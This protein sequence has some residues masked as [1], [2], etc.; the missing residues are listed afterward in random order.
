MWGTSSFICLNQ[1]LRIDLAIKNIGKET[2]MYKEIT[3]PYG[4]STLNVRLPGRNVVAVL[5][6]KHVPGLKDERAAIFKAL[7]QPVDSPPLK[8]CLKPTDKVVIIVTDNTRA[9][10]DERLLPVIL[11]EL[12]AKIPVTNITILIALGLHAPLSR[13]EQIKKLG[14]AIVEKYQVVNHDPNH[15]V[16]L[17][18]TSFG[19]SVEVNSIV[20]EADFRI[21]TGFIEPHFFA[22]FSGGRKSIAPGV[23]SARAI[24]NNHCYAMVGHP[25]A[26][27]GILEGNPVHED[28]V[29]Q[30]KMAKLDFIL[31]VLLNAQ[32]QITH[33][34]AGNP[35]SAHIAGCEIEKGIVQSEI[36]HKVDITIVTNGGAPL[37]LDFY[38]TVKGI[39]TAAKITRPGGAIIVAS[40]CHAGV[41][42]ADFKALHSGCQSPQEVLEKIKCGPTAG[43]DWQ[44]QILAFAQLDHSIF[45]YS[46]LADDEVKSMLVNP[47]RS[48][49]EGLEKAF[50]LLGQEAEI[51]VIPEGPMVLPVVN[52]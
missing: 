17:G 37:D 10:P 50:K 15:T 13:E 45:L 31:N 14:R 24:R 33:V 35:W 16:R 51:A 46:K 43:V 52:G 21:S 22:G 47:V 5:E 38:Q 36:D 23:S 34:L 1:K 6:A 40:S 2:L 8:D 42:S 27:A 7:R 19:T 44:N 48:V 41:G 28:Q 39:D 11:E 4:D 32:K 49:E 9:C 12:A 30:A 26:Q 18:T 3:L 29:E 20:F 25:K